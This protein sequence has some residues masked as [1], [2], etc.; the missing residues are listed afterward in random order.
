MKMSNVELFPLFI[1]YSVNMKNIAMDTN[2]NI[3]NITVEYIHN[4]FLLILPLSE[5]NI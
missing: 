4:S 1:M 2:K 5:N 3:N